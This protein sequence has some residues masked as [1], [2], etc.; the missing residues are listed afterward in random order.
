M[1]VYI[2]VAVANRKD[3]EANDL[4]QMDQLRSTVVPFAPAYMV[5]AINLTVHPNVG[6]PGHMSSSIAWLGFPSRENM[7]PTDI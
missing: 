2:L 5:L 7:M 4:R 6:L 3:D 1:M